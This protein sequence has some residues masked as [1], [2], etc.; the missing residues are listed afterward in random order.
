VSEIQTVR[1]GVRIYPLNGGIILVKQTVKRGPRYVV[2][3]QRELH[4]NIENDAAL[5][6]A[7]RAALKG[8]LG[9]Q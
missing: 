6:A 5:G 7:V 4:V 1:N 3:G 9:T 8:Q 2:D